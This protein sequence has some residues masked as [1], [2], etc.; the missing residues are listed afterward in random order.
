MQCAKINKC[1]LWTPLTNRYNFELSFGCSHLR[2]HWGHAC[3]TVD[4]WKYCTHRSFYWYSVKSLPT[5]YFLID[6]DQFHLHFYNIRHCQLT[7]TCV[8][9][10]TCGPI[11]FPKVLWIQLLQ[12]NFDFNALDMV[13]IFKTILMVTNWYKTEVAQYFDKWC[14][15]IFITKEKMWIKKGILWVKTS[16][17][18]AM[19][20]ETT[21][22]P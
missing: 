11:V 4:G 15:S 3:A 7:I 13:Q 2:V 9:M 17:G 20:C 12:V 16:E 14:F 8:T 21:W 22:H 1:L 18:R 6:S 5:N 19:L 10:V